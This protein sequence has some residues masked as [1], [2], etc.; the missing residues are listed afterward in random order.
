MSELSLDLLSLLSGAANVKDAYVRLL[1]RARLFASADAALVLRPREAH[2]G[3]ELI[4]PLG[5]GLRRDYLFATS[6]NR[7]DLVEGEVVREDKRLMFDGTAA[8]ANLALKTPGSDCA[9]AI[10]RLEWVDPARMAL[11]PLRELRQALPFVAPLIHSL[12]KYDSKISIHPSTADPRAEA[13]DDDLDTIDPRQLCR[14]A[15]GL[16]DER[17]KLESAAIYVLAAGEFQ[18]APGGVFGKA[19]A[20]EKLPPF[21]KVAA[22]ERRIVA[23]EKSLAVPVVFKQSSI[24]LALLVPKH[25]PDASALA[26]LSD[27][28][29]KAALHVQK[30]RMYAASRAANAAMPLLLVGV[31]RDV[32]EMAES[33]ADAD[34]P[35][36]IK[37]ETGTGKESIARFV[38][39][40]GARR[41]KPFLPFNCA[42]LSEHLAE[43]QLFGHMKGAFTGAVADT[44]GLFEQAHGGTLFLDEIHGLS[45]AVQAKFL[46][47]VET[48][49]IRPVGGTPKRV[50]VRIIVATNQDLPALV[51]GGRFL[52]D[53][54]MRLDVLELA[55]APLR[56]NRRALGRIAD[57]LLAECSRRNRKEV[58]ALTPRARQAI[59]G[60]DYPGNIRELKNV[61][62]KAV[63]MTKQ[64]YIDIDVLPKKVLGAKADGPAPE[65]VF[66]PDYEN[67]KNAAERS[68]LVR[69]LERCGGSIT[70]AA[71]LSGLHRT[72]IYNLIKKHALNAERF[73]A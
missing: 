62:E 56:A 5:R 60:Y 2:D 7:P 30:A 4:V 72:H 18:L 9:G 66:E 39:H 1:D 63:V 50:D 3:H 19:G 28:L 29:A 43:S 59:L 36:L 33:Y 41:A 31:P 53:L 38:H 49:E 12:R 6:V 34:A 46:R 61:L 54:F 65:D 13:F 20:P 73:R 23:H 22:A 68:Y 70:E 26:F 51:A 64:P 16:I 8:G 45:P 11:E 44:P 35:V 10:L 52:H 57:A 47:A 69:L 27:G 42:E 37:G 17:I 15:Y 25:K 14:R 32:L 24:A 58:H 48:G 21:A 71:K 40:A 55:L 67:F